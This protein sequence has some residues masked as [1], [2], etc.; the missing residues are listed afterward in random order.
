MTRNLIET[1]AALTRQ[2]AEALKTEGDAGMR[3]AI[4]GRIDRLARAARYLRERAAR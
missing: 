4:R 1:M 3:R 2:A